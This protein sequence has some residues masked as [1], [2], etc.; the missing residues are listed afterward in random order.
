MPSPAIRLR[1]DDA[2][3]L[4]SGAPGWPNA[5]AEDLSGAPNRNCYCGVG[6]HPTARKLFGCQAAWSVAMELQF[7]EFKV[8]DAA[9]DRNRAGR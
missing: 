6:L 1:T 3:V 7:L 9:T 4:P 8:P 2:G 5:P